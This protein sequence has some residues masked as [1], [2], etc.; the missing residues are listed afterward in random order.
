VANHYYRDLYL[1]L[2]SLNQVS[3]SV[4]EYYK[5]IEITMI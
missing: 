2:Q 1:K 5:E 3:T 4:D